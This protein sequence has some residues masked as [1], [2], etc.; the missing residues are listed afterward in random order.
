VTVYFI[1]SKTGNATLLHECNKTGSV[2][3][4]EIVFREILNSLKSEYSLLER[5]GNKI[6]DSMDVEV[7]FIPSKEVVCAKIIPTPFLNI[8][9][10]SIQEIVL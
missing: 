3:Y 1:E 7:T 8:D 9:Q 2:K 10:I 6:P 4:D 5:E